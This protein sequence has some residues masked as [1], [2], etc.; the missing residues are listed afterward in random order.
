MVRT[1]STQL[2]GLQQAIKQGTYEDCG[3]GNSTTAACGQNQVEGKDQAET[4][5]SSQG[6]TRP[7]S[8]IFQGERYTALAQNDLQTIGGDLISAQFVYLY[9][10]PKVKIETNTLA[11][12]IKGSK[13]TVDKTCEVELNWEGFE[14]I[15]MFYVAHLSGW[16]MIVGKPA[17]QDVRATISAGTAPVTIQP[18]GMDRFPL[19]MWRG[20]R[21]TV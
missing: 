14:E 15:R 19:R 11:T 16:D 21:V 12:A 3:T 10:L 13:G 4:S 7:E 8:S 20:N 17:R 6:A 1:C 5:S 9:K 18:P 2:Q